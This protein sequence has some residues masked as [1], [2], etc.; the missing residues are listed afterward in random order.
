MRL[1]AVRVLAMLAVAR[2]LSSAASAPR[3]VLVSGAGGQ[4]GQSLFRKMLAL[5]D[6]FQPVGLVRTEASKATLVESG[7]PES[8]VVVVDVMS[9]AAG[10]QT[11]AAGCDAMC[12][13][14]S[15][16]PA[17]TGDTDPDSGR[18]IFGFPNGTP[19][20]VDWIGQKH[21]IDAC[22]PGAHVLICSSMG[23]TDPNH[24]LNNLGRTTNPDGTTSGGNILM[25]KRKAEV[26]LTKSGRD[27]TIV[28]PGGL[29]NEPG[30]ERELVLGVDD[31]MDGTE[32][33]TVPREDVAEVMLQALRHSNEYKN[34]SFDLRAKPPG[35]G[36]PT[37]DF[38]ALADSLKGKNC[39]YSLG[40][41]M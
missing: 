39:D 4:T 17:P 21:Q 20:Q 33:R 5:P 31:S 6:A 40:E 10:V 1:V 23:G 18:P 22:P 11:A 30:S 24:P 37:T 32:S 9:D 26:Y 2:A 28:H 3:K 29:L 36:T 41:T 38:K 19:D 15:A 35:D 34:R 25:W 8:S 27:Y 7:V 14:T 16:K 12:I 13:C